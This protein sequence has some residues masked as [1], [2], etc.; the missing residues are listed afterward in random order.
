MFEISEGEPSILRS[1]FSTAKFAK[2]R[3]LPKAFTEK[4][5]YMLATILR[6][7]IRR[8]GLKAHVNL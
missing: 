7:S 5:L 2:T 6:S 8:T 1:K 4:S 3:A